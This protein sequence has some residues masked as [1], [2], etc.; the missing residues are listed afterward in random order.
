MG[1]LVL[2]GIEQ[3]F[4]RKVD[5]EALIDRESMHLFAFL[6]SDFQQVV[7]FIEVDVLSKLIDV[8]ADRRAVDSESAGD[9]GSTESS[10]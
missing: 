7:F 5:R 10:G 6:G 3:H 8:P 4:R 9:F 1:V 2:A